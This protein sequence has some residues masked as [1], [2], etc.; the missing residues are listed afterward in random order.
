MGN[1]PCFRKSRKHHN[2]V[3]QDPKGETVENIPGPTQMTNSDQSAFANDIPTP[4]VE[5]ES[6]LVFAPT[7]KPKKR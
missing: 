2:K 1:C 4:R 6:D 3:S 7:V 5:T